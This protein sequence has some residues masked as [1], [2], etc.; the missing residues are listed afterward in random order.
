METPYVLEAFVGLGGEDITWLQM[1][2][3]AVLVFLAGVALVRLAGKRA[4]GNWSALDI[5]LSIILGSSLSRALTGNAPFVQTLVA[6]TVLVLLYRLVASGTARFHGLGRLVKG[7]AAKLISEGE[8]DRAALRR[9]RL[10]DHDLEEA[11]RSPGV[12][13]PSEVRA[14]YI[15]RGGDISVLKR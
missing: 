5:I 13:D 11:L 10:G 6:M 14:A 8:V 1:S 9:H 3:R 12:N 4:F 2:V 7:E 15:E